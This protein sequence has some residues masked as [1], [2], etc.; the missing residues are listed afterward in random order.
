M[1]SGRIEK[2][3][4]PWNTSGLAYVGA[5]LGIAL[6]TAH[7]FHHVR[8]DDIPEHNVIVHIFGELFAAT[9]IGALLLAGV[10]E[11]RNRRL[12]RES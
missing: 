8:V 11:I 3:R 1:S 7:H 4:R 12:K 10:A 2:T 9:I 5:F 6:A